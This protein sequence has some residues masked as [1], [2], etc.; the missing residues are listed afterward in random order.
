M[1]EKTFIHLVIDKSSKYHNNMLNR[2]LSMESLNAFQISIIIVSPV[3]AGILIYISFS[4][5]IRRKKPQASSLP[6]SN[7]IKSYQ[8]TENEILP[9]EDKTETDPK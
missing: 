5:L 3:I 4:L 7:D 1:R 6:K 8:V 9:D 2:G